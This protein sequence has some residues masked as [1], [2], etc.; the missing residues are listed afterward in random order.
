MDETH[1]LL[2]YILRR[3]A[4]EV[5]IYYDSQ[6][7][8]DPLFFS[9]KTKILLLMND[10]KATVI[11]IRWKK[12]SNQMEA[13]PGALGE[14]G[15]GG[16]DPCCS[17]APSANPGGSWLRETVAPRRAQ[18]RLR[19]SPQRSGA[20]AARRPPCL[21]LRSRP[22]SARGRESERRRPGR[23]GQ[24]GPRAPVP[25]RPRSVPVWP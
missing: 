14:G 23:L 18:P 5:C 16:I 4:P 22:S 25:G 12:H 13:G 20:P 15:G 6:L 10:L 17:L 21:P 1:F 3:K 8:W 9:F 24:G 7:Q 19:A 2:S 11:L